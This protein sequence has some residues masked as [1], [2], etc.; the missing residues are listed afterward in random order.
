MKNYQNKSR[1]QRKGIY[2]RNKNTIARAYA[3]TGAHFSTYDILDGAQWADIMFLGQNRTVYSATILT[4]RCAWHDKVESE[5]FS[6][7]WQELNE[8]Q[9]DKATQWHSDAN[10]GL[11]SLAEPLDGVPFYEAVDL[12][13]LKLYPEVTIHCG[14][15]LLNDFTYAQGIDMIIDA[16]ELSV[17]NINQ[18]IADFIAKG[19]NNWQ[20]SQGLQF[21][22]DKKFRYIS[23]PI[24]LDDV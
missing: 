7:V 15:T 19:E 1:K 13:E 16:E 10:T 20:D 9:K 3:K 17:A 5:A 24:N 18:G 21:E 11:N 2:I 4:A 22:Y 8:E 14:Y 23:N 6:S 12:A